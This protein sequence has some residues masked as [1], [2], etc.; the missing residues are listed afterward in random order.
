VKLQKSVAEIDLKNLSN[1]LKLVKSRTGNKK[2]LAVVK[3]DAYGHGAVTISKHLL[4]NR[5]AMLGVA[6][7]AEGMELRDAGI[8][9]PIVVFFDTKNIDAFLK[10]DLTPV[11][12][13]LDTAKKISIAASQKKKVVPIHIKVD[14][15]MGRVGFDPEKA[16]KAIPN[17]AKLKN[18]KVEGL[19]SHFSDADLKNK[20]FAHQQIRKFNRVIASLKEIGIT[21][22]Y[23][24]MANSA[25]VLTLPES[26][27]NM[28]RPGIMLYGYG[29]CESDKLRPVMSLRS[30]V[31]FVK[32]VPK[33][34]P[35]SY[36]RTF[37]TKRRSTIA[38]IPVGYADGYN[39]ILSNKGRVIIN[40][41][42]A[43]IAGR[44]CMD[45]FMVDAT[46]IPNVNRNSE[47]ILIGSKGRKK[48]TA[49]DIAGLTGTIPYEVLTSIGKRVERVYK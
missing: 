16:L 37:V 14:T 17:M 20:R 28:V 31:L 11:V 19:M 27:F 34:T 40:G 4:K 49:D 22:K 42:F 25:A 29:C 23:I 5:V 8:K 44:V 13:D 26:H 21:F 41:K 10:Y 36:G 35:I 1:N 3:A 45:A 46:G 48:I 32:S 30:K 6:S 15:G 24:H 12:F 9:A 43:P 33:G 18:I 38:T 7:A 47:A 2:I 39:R